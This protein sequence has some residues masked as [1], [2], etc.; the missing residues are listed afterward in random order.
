MDLGKEMTVSKTYSLGTASVQN[1]AYALSEFLDVKKNM[2]TQTMRT[3]D[4]YVVQCKGDASAE[5]T[6]YIGLDAAVTVHLFAIDGDLIVDIG[7]EKW[8]EKLGIAAA[9][10][11]FFQP[12]LIT[13]GIGAIRQMALPNEIF[14]F[15][16]NYL[17]TEPVEKSF[18]SEQGGKICPVC[19]TKAADNAVFCSE[20]GTRFAANAKKV[21]PRCGKELTGKEK[22]C[23]ECGTKL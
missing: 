7:T 3:K 10:S 1:V 17:G 14:S 12:L 19:G 4:G 22:F 6:K 18:P 8:L 9:G 11:L 13:S 5:W 21:C 23:S 15:I 2:I 20:C 16:S